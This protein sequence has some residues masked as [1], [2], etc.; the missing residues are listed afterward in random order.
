M[1]LGIVTNTE[2][3]NLKLNPRAEL[4]TMKAGTK[5]CYVIVWLDDAV[6]M[7]DGLEAM[8]I[9]CLSEDCL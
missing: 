4:I 9:I 7:F 6:Y 5:G 1:G 3:G 8:V 2:S